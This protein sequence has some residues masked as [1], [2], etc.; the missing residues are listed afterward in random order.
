MKVAYANARFRAKAHDGANAHV[1]QFVQNAVALG[2]EIWMW[3]GVAHPLAK[4]LPS[5]RL[6]RTMKLREMDVLYVRLENDPAKACKWSVGATRKLIGRALH[7]WE[8]NTSPEYGLTRGWTQERVNG[9]IAEFKRLAPGCD[10]AVCV[11]EALSGYVRDRLGFKR[12]VTVPNGSDPDLYTPNATPPARVSKGPNVFNVLWIGS[13]YAA[14]HNFEL[15]AGAARLLWERGNPDNIVFHLLGQGMTSMRDMPPNVHYYGMEDYEKLPHWMAAMD[16]GL[17]LYKPGASDYNSPLKVFD[18]MSSGLAVVSTA[19]PQVKELFETLAQ[20]DLLV[21]PEDPAALAETLTR[22]ARD[23]AR[24]ANVG[25]AARKLLIEKFTWRRA[26]T[27]TFAAIEALRR[28]EPLNPDKNSS[29]PYFSSQAKISCVMPMRN[30]ASYVGEA[31]R[32]VLDQSAIVEL[33]VVDDGSTDGSGDAVRAINDPRIKIVPGPKTGIADA[34]NAGLAHATGELFCRCDADDAYAANRL[35][36]Q[37][38]FLA[39]HPEF[40]AVCCGYRAVDEKLQPIADPVSND[41]PGEITSELREGKGRTHFNTFL[42]RME[43]VRALN[44]FRSY[45]IG[46][47]DADFQLRLG[48]LTRVWFEP[49]I[50]YYYRL[51]GE[52]ITHTQRSR[53]RKFFEQQA[54]ACQVQRQRGETDDVDRKLAPPPPA[55]LADETIETGPQIQRLLLGQAWK[56]H[57]RGHRAAAMRTGWRAVAAGPSQLNAWRSL[58]ALALK[59]PKSENGAA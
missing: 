12:A 5:N 31:V 16:V 11:S 8:F 46:T 17:C 21:P 29:R 47:E 2:H 10:L 42:V 19:Q 25:A 38:Q 39:E 54:R 41:Q 57:R 49:R 51:H 45:F 7:V 13:A 43:H 20:T 18:Y 15:L 28:G 3:P 48:D 59:S 56:E 6:A 35:A 34:L 27:D 40:G 58:L 33:I 50:G 53:E 55:N 22:L 9:D 44:G 4:A 32:S 14:W 24:V 1:R 26:V 30:C 37:A 36:W 52:S 23:R